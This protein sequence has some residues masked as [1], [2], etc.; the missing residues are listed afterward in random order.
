MSRRINNSGNKNMD[1]DF[2][3]SIFDRFPKEEIAK[4]YQELM[5][6]EEK[7]S[8]RAE[9]LEKRVKELE[10]AL[11]SEKAEKEDIQKKAKTL[12]AE[13][14][15]LYKRVSEAQK[16]TSPTPKAGDKPAAGATSG[17]EI[18]RSILSKSGKEEYDALIDTLV[19]AGE[20]KEKLSKESEKRLKAKRA[21]SSL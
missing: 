2:L 14:D 1:S 20:K 21:I 11:V 13:N 7:S 15:E 12:K 18:D 6:K 16:A 17:P 5:E 4:S 19:T 9:E 10:K 8:K 3:D